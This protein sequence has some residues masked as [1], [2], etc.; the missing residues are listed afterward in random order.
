MELESSA[1]AWV[2]QLSA[3][4]WAAQPTMPRQR[5]PPL[6]ALQEAAKDLKPFQFSWLWKLVQIS[7]I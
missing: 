7:E 4:S 2:L 1:G 5:L 6:S 3:A